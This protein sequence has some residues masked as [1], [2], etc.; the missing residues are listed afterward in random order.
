LNSP[1]HRPDLI[2]ESDRR[3][4]GITTSCQRGQISRVPLS[5][6]KRLAKGSNVNAEGSFADIYVRPDPFEQLVLGHDLICVLNQNDE[7]IEGPTT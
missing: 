6:P 5:I 2:R 7:N 3:N 4:E 1:R